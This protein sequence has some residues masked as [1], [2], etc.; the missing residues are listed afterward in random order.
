MTN[1]QPTRLWGGRFADGPSDAMA[2]L[3]LSTPSSTGGWRP[4]TCAGRA[5]TRTYLTGRAC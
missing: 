1:E 5:R 3:S 2:A 4:M